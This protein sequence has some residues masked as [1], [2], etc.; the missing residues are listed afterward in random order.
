M[1]TISQTLYNDLLP[2]LGKHDVTKELLQ[3]E[4]QYVEEATSPLQLTYK[5]DLKL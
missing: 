5:I 1:V 4:L 3:M 2:Y